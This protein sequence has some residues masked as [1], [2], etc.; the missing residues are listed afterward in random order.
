MRRIRMPFGAVSLPALA[1]GIS[2]CAGGAPVASASTS[3]SFGNLSSS[4]AVLSHSIQSEQQTL[5][6]HVRVLRRCQHAHPN[7]C[8]RDTNAAQLARRRLRHMNARL[9]RRIATA[10]RINKLAAP[11]VTVSGETLSWNKVAGAQSYVLMRMVPGQSATYTNLS[12]TSA[13][14][15]AASGLTVGYKVRTQATHS[16][17]SSEVQI[18]YPSP[19]APQSSPPP[20]S[21]PEPVSGQ[22]SPPSVEQPVVTETPIE[23]VTA[24]VL[25]ATG[26]TYYVSS[27]GSDQN[28][29]TSPTQAWRT[30]K[31]VNS[32]ALAPGD[33]VLFEGSATFSDETL[34]PSVSGTPGTPIIFGSYGTGDAILPKGVWFKGVNYLAFEGFSIGSEGNLQGT[35]NGIVV[36]RCSIGNDGLAIN[37]TGSNSEWTIVDNTINNTGNSGMLLEGERFTV[38]GNTITNTGLDASIPYG[39]HGI[40]LK[41][42]DATVTDNTISN[43]SADGIS[44]R[45]RNS[46]V[47]GNHISDGPIGIAWF[48][49]D[50]IAG[51]SYWANNVI[52]GTTEA[53]IF[54]SSP[55]NSEEQTI[56][57]FAIEHNTIQPASGVFM[58][59]HEIAGSYTVADNT[60]L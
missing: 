27:H 21:S 20:S 32:A 23:S 57:S 16:A 14:P 46:T 40:Y 49:A 58:N 3:M 28:S 11:L 8:R 19:P 12:G 17:W 30:V 38:S 53:G 7:R 52:S 39:K 37:A 10:Q 4:V 1:V 56:E 44:V 42:S 45:Y 31:R 50:T 34:M 13:T 6:F 5:A 22:S 41:V 9:S 26:T 59:L 36:E 24:P 29:G 55:S 48:Q 18:A 54:V 15:P 43:F 47:V 35:G 2:I 33:A 25:T 51:S 60:M